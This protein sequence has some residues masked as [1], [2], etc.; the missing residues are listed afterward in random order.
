MVVLGDRLHASQ[1]SITREIMIMGILPIAPKAV[2]R[3]LFIFLMMTPMVLYSCFANYGRIQRDPAIQQAFEQNRVRSDYR[4]YY[5][6]FDTRPY[7]IIGVDAKFEAGSKVWR[8]VQTDTAQFK[9]MTRWVW[10]DYGY[11]LFGAHILDPQGKTVGVYYSSIFE[12]AIKFGENNRIMVM[13]HTPFLWGPEA[14]TNNVNPYYA[15]E[16]R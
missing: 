10:E 15:F 1:K 8:E 11:S 7:A 3:V 14:N 5:Y 2:R 16:R 6:G 9:E 13:P 4:Y 12:V